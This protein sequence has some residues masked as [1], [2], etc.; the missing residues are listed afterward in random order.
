MAVPALGAQ[1]TAAHCWGASMLQTYVDIAAGYGLLSSEELSRLAV[2]ECH[3][4]REESTSAAVRGIAQVVC[5]VGAAESEFSDLTAPRRIDGDGV[6][7]LVEAAAAAGVEQFIMVTSLGTGK[8]RPAE[9]VCTPRCLGPPLL[10][11][12]LLECGTSDRPGGLP[13]LHPEPV[14]RRADIQAPGRDCA[15]GQRAA[16]RDCAPRYLC[17]RQPALY[18]CVGCFL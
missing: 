10:P 8:V 3:L 12:H 5:A 17:M 16:L 18:R 13:C 7:R 4:E 1:G 11:H 15:G 2:V 14:W 9:R 6:T